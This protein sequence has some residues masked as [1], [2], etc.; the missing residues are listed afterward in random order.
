MVLRRTAS[1]MGATAAAALAAAALSTVIAPDA[2]ARAA[3]SSPAGSTPVPGPERR[4]KL[5][6]DTRT[7]TPETAGTMSG[8]PSG[9]PCP[10]SGTGAGSHEPAAAPAGT[11]AV[12]EERSARRD[13]DGTCWIAPVEWLPATRAGEPPHPT[14]LGP[15]AR[16]TTG[17]GR[18]AE[19][20]D[21]PV[22]YRSHSHA[23]QRWDRNT[24]TR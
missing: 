23:V 17:G 5:H 22:R 11:G 21:S 7:P 12:A 1:R 10:P 14:A 9:P 2:T 4:S 15:M 18:E 16:R 19:G 8:T 20:A 3:Q 13:P 24:H 6:E